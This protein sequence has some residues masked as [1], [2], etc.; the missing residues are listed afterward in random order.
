[1]R[2]S[3]WRN[4]SA[5]TLIELLVVIA[6][7]AILIGLLLPAVQKVREAAAR[8][9]SSNNLKQLSLACH[10]AQDSRGML[11]CAWNAWWMHLGDPNGNPGGYIYGT[12]KGPWKTYNG[13]VTLF[14]HL[15]P[16]IEQDAVYRAG[17]GQQL[18]SYASGQRVWTI[19]LKTLKAAHDPSPK[20]DQNL[21]YGWLEGGAVTPWSTTS[22]SFNYQLFGERNGN[23]Y[24]SN[25]W[26]TSYKIETIPDGSSQTMFFAEKM[27][28]CGSFGNMTFHGGWNLDYC[29]TF[30]ARYGSAAKFQVQ[31]T[32]SNCD[33]FLPTAF[34]ASGI[35]VSM[36]DGSVRGVNAGVSV[37]T[38]GQATDPADG[39]VLGSNW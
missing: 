33:R 7:I 10:N 28:V 8:M 26:G 19:K 9:S 34:T 14:Y 39:Q 23:P 24:D 29:P 37:A 2:L 30:G 15:M 11:P 25:K 17:N 6:I 18:F 21:A 1:M 20:D 13:D 3:H 16:F 32:Q 38:W 27:M 36:G 4:R 22:Y 35:Q 31:P 12:Y 5:F